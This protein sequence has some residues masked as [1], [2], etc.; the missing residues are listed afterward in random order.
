MINALCVVA[1]PDD[2]TIWMGGMIL[3]NPNWNWTI[4]SLCRQNDSD[5]MPKFKKVCKH[6]GA[7]AMI[8]D[9]EDDKL[10]PIS[11][12]DIKNKIT[13]ELKRKDFDYIFTHGKNGEYGHIRHIEIHNAVNELINEG[14]L[15]CKKAYGFSYKPGKINAPHDSGLKIPVPSKNA[16]S[17]I[18][19]NEEEYM[20]KIKIIRDIYGFREGI[21][22]TLSCNQIESF[23]ELK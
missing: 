14:K 19:L 11:I 8:S 9:L 12:L 1:H 2:E 10:Y 4:F 15:S 5:R 20:E 23:V 17:K 16:N 21:F 13:K 6:Y 22:E 7:K 18:N 3:K